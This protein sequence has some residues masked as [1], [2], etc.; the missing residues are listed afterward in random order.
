M[1]D[2]QLEAQ[3]A[4]Q[5]LEPSVGKIQISTPATFLMMLS[6]VLW[7]TRWRWRCLAQH[8]AQA[9]H[10]AHA[11]QSRSLYET[12]EAVHGAKHCMHHL[13]NPLA[14]LMWY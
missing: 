12:D 4:Q 6:T 11:Q 10:A 7:A 3:P 13:S 5:D 8:A 2:A 1:V 9:Q 14:A